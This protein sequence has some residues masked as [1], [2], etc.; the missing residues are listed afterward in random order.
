M[1]NIIKMSDKQIEVNEKQTNGS[2]KD[3]PDREL[4]SNIRMNYTKQLM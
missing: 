4:K 2:N 3:E 1:N